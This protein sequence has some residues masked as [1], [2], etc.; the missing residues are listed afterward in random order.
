[1][2]RNSVFRVV[3]NQERQQLTACGKNGEILEISRQKPEVFY[4]TWHKSEV[5]SLEVHGPI[6]DFDDHDVYLALTELLHDF[7][8]GGGKGTTLKT[9]FKEIIEKLGKSD[10]SGKNKILLRRSLKRLALMRLIYSDHKGNSWVGG[11]IE[12]AVSQGTGRGMKVVV[13]FNPYVVPSYNAGSYS[14]YY[15]LESYR[16][17]SQL[18]RGIYNFLTSHGDTFFMHLDKWQRL[19]SQD[20]VEH[21]KF[22]FNLKKSLEELIEINFLKKESF[23]DVDGI[24]HTFRSAQALP[25]V[26]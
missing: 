5:S 3:S 21:R 10:R 25:L 6:C 19:L 18:A 2:V 15:R 20:H 7:H 8:E 23:I 1:M 24:V 16:K 4:D 11:I 22:K 9:T 12:S 14:K 17:C 13:S 26:S